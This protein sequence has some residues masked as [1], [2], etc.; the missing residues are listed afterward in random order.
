MNIFVAKKEYV[1]FRLITSL[2][3]CVDIN[4]TRER[5]NIYCYLIIICNVDIYRYCSSSYSDL[6]SNSS[7]H[8]IQFMA[9]C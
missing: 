9:S 2:V 6:G 7:L 1:S 5:K 3:N 8:A 4:D